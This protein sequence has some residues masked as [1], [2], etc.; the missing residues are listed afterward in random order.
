MFGLDPA[1]AQ[2]VEKHSSRFYKIL[3]TSLKV[4]REEI[5]IISDYGKGGNNLSNMLGYGYYRAA[6]SKG[7]NVNLLFQEVKKGFMFADDH[8]VNA[9]EKLEKNNIIIVAASNKLGRMGEQKSFRSFC[10]E[11]GHRFLSATGL[12]D[13]NSGYFNLFLEAM[14]VNYARM[15]KKG[16]AIKKIW[17][18]AEEIRVKTDAGTDVTFN[19]S[20]MKAIANIGE[21]HK[22]STGGNM[23]AGEV[24][25]APQGYQGV[26]GVVVIDGSIKTDGGAL[27]IDKPVKMYIQEGRVVK[28]EGKYAQLLE[29]TFQKYEERAKFPEHVRHIS[30]LG[31]GINPGAVLIGSMIMDEKVLGTGHI[32]VGSNYWFGGQIKTVYHGDQI[33]KNP[34]FYVDGKKMEL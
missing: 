3:K 19:V 33:F 4:K 2:A 26:N 28:V 16:L 30:E 14:N 18:K 7:L 8:I 17:D 32:A 24:Y 10:K 9:I 25:I 15:K 13:V 31:I 5:L 12:G 29:E 11:R 27:L 34:I 20:G 6:R 23:P 22:P 21:Y 1:T